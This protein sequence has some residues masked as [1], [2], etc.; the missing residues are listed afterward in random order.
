MTTTF[1]AEPAAPRLLMALELGRREWKLGFTT[2]VGRATRRRTVRADSWRRVAEEIAASK[3]RF[4]V[5]A[6]APVI[7]C[8][9]AGLDGFWVHR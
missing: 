3:A 9:E 4:G 8:Y 5:S 7:S 2:G 1:D 6:D